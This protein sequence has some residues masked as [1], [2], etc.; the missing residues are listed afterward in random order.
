MAVSEKSLN[1]EVM[2]RLCT[3]IV[4]QAIKDYAIVEERINVIRFF[5]QGYFNLMTNLDAK[6]I[7]EECE[8]RAVKLSYYKGFAIR[9]VKDGFEQQ[10]RNGKKVYYH[11]KTQREVIEHIKK[12]IV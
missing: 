2:G 6:I 12:E 4:M 11:A 7:L 1:Q 5:R 3:A 9:Q 10:S 8:K